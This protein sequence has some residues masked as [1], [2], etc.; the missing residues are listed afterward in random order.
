MT[1]AHEMLR[2]Y[3]LDELMEQ[4]AS[5]SNLAYAADDADDALE[6]IVEIRRCRREIEWRLANGVIVK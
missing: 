4:V 5:W 6:A 1:L 3:T 2:L